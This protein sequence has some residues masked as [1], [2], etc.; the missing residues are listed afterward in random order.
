MILAQEAA[1][2]ANGAQKPVMYSVFWNSLWGS[3]WGATMGVSY[4]LVS[5]IQIRES[6]ITATTIGGV[7]GYGLGIYLVVSG[8]SFDKS[9]LLKLPSP[10]FKQ[11]AA[12][13]IEAEMLPLYARSE[14]P[15]HSKWEVPIFAFSF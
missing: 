13:F 12:A 15:D 9:F 6:L 1:L 5:G 2:P 3:A 7:L 10:N 4:H 14:K 11:P 8:L